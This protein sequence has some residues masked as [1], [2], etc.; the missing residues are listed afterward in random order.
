MRILT[1]SLLSWIRNL[2]EQTTLIILSA[3][4]MALLCGS[5]MVGFSV[6]ESLKNTGFNRLGRARYLVY[7][8][9]PPSESLV[10]R[11]AELPGAVAAL[12]ET[13]A[14]S[15]NSGGISAV[16]GSVYGVDQNFFN[17][18]EGDTAAPEIGQVV[19]NARLAERLGLRGGMD[20]TVNLKNDPLIPVD[21]PLSE[22]EFGTISLNMTI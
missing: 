5:V 11:F 14:V 2:K 10:S 6:K 4:S 21:I 17:L 8:A 18:Y 1:L 15:V 12:T 22:G 20:L 16:N 19:I 9:V 3:V 7:P 13:K